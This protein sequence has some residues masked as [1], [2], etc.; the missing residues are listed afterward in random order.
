MTM[1][2]NSRIM[3]LAAFVMLLVLSC[4][5][6]NL[7]KL[8]DLIVE[9]P[10]VSSSQL[11]SGSGVTVS[12]RVKN[13]GHGVADF[14]LTQLNGLYYFLSADGVYD[15]GDVSLGT[16]NIDDINP[17]NT[18]DITGKSLTIPGGTTPG[19]YYIL[20][21]I[22]FEDDIEEFNEDNNVAYV[23]IQVLN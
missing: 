1:K 20:F 2:M 5:G 23:V 4:E 13:Q 22:D 16:S 8:P 18:K 19:N 3:A 9:N 11:N 14:P 17:G 12:C 10:G 15:A 7:P 21:Y 6:Y